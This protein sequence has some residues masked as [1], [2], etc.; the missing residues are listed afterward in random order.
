MP[1]CCVV[2]HLLRKVEAGDSSGGANSASED[3]RNISA[4]TAD[5]ERILAGPRAAPLDS[6]AFPD[7][8]LAKAEEV[9]ELVVNRGDAVEERLPRC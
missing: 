7:V 3:C 2:E 8:M 9:V 1:P 6:H 5:V 4:A